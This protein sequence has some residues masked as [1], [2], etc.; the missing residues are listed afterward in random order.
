[1]NRKRRTANYWLLTAFIALLMVILPFLDVVDIFEGGGAMIMVGAT[2]FFTA[3]IVQGMFRK[4]ARI[5][6]Q[7]ESGEAE[8][9]ARW[10]YTPD[11]WRAYVEMQFGT[12]KGENRLLF[13]MLVVITGLVIVPMAI[14][15][16]DYLIF[17]GIGAG[18]LVIVLP[19][20]LWAPGLTRRNLLKADPR[21]LIS[22]SG[23]L[24]G[25][26]LHP[27][28]GY[29]NR[30]EQVT[31]DENVISFTYSFLSGKTR[32]S[33]TVP[34]PAPSNASLEVDGVMTYFL[35]LDNT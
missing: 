22:P 25:H 29:G 33:R 4:H 20:A 7:L 26:Q 1:M 2:L 5:W 15:T 28:I 23:L 13:I 34:V 30:L 31:R 24:V 12:T 17:L 9:L 14:A 21:I 19:F 18:I 3:I 11:E 10:R 32:Q 27:F 16:G 8:T 6:D 35:S